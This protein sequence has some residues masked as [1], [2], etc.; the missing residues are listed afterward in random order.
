LEEFRSY[1]MVLAQARLDSR[2]R[3]KIDPSDAVQQT[4][5][6]AC[7]KWDQH[8][9]A[10]EA[11]LAAWLRSI[12][13]R[14]LLHYVR[15]YRRNKR[16]IARERSL[17]AALAESSARLER[18]LEAEESSPSQHVLRVDEALKV[19]A[20]VQDLPQVQRDAVVLYYWQGCSLAKVGE[21]LGRSTS[22]AAGL[23]RRAL[24]RLR[25]QVGGPE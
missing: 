16:D 18:W 3:G 17:E 4:L 8:R 12:L 6:Q 11:E 20:S 13:A 2:L 5:L 24:Q 25:G 19:A 15:D 22:A 10:S 7:R 21:H 14:M 1:L 23:I 9:G